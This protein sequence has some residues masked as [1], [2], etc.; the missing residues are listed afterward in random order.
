M[1]TGLLSVADLTSL[2]IQHLIESA[3]FLKR[4]R[5]ANALLKGKTIALLFE[6]PSLRTRASFE[7]AMWQ[8]GGHAIYLS[9]A[10]V[11]LGKRESISDV[12]RTLSR[13]VNGIVARTFAHET[14]ELLAK[15]GTVPV[16]NGLSD[17]EH[18]CQALGDLLTI[19]EK[20]GDLKGL[21][22]A[23]VGDGNN[24]ARSLVLAAAAVGMDFSIASPPGYELD[25]SALRR[26][27][28]LASQSGAKIAMMS[29]P[30]HAVDNADVL[31]TDV[32]TSMGQEAESRIRRR[33]FTSYQVDAAL[34]SRAREGALF[35]HPLPAHHGE[36]IAKG[37]LDHPQSVVFDQAENRLHIQKAILVRALGGKPV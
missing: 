13:F 10:E 14:V 7:V 31:Y 34:L 23:Y 18:P 30:R 32:W 35:M 25:K 12:A 29:E 36:E 27:K 9:P 28:K 24:V 6:K 15:Y 4:G 2:E 5:K 21:R 11:G 26:A 1:S 20:K 17:Y 33:A 3:A 22:L 16:I 8:L 37:L 19:V